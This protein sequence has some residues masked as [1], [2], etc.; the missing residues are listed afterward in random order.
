MEYWGRLIHHHL[1][2]RFQDYAALL[3]H[4]RVYEYLFGRIE[5]R[6]AILDNLRFKT[7]TRVITQELDLL[8]IR[9]TTYLLLSIWRGFEKLRAVHLVDNHRPTPAGKMAECPFMSVDT[10]A[11]PTLR[12]LLEIFR[13]HNPQLLVDHAWYPVLLTQVL[14]ILWSSK[15]PDDH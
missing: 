12:L 11:M 4:K 5:G 1:V 13:H 8:Q 9:L 3:M 15:F 14:E 10:V 7:E 2:A 6:P